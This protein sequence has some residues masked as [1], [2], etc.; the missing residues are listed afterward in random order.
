[1]TE[2]AEEDYID[3]D[4]HIRLN[5]CFYF[6]ILLGKYPTTD[7]GLAAAIKDIPWFNKKI[8]QDDLNLYIIMTE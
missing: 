5:R 8:Y 4:N 6:R 1:L 3:D 2:I 7:D